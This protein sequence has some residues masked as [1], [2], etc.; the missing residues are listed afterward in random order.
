[1]SI[2]VHA[3]Y[4]ISGDPPTRAHMDILQRASR[5]YSKLTWGLGINLLK[6]SFL[7]SELR[8]S[9]MEDC[10]KELNISGVE[11]VHYRGPTSHFARKIGAT[12]LIRGLR[13]HADLENEM[14]LAYGN[15]L[16]SPNLETVL[17]FSRPEYS[18]VSS[19][20]TR[21]LALLQAPLDD[22]IPKK[23]AERMRDYL[24]QKRLQ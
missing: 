11:I 8:L 20:L 13:N 18:H 19:N 3:L 21:E 2:S 16:L 6:T 14:Q 7:P 9:M 17:L 15:R 10:L 24:N 4:P 1:M 22:L 23:A 12:V 5:L